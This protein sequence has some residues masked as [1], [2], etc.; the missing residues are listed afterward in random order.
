MDSLDR[1]LT[2]LH[3]SRLCLF[4]GSTGLA[5]PEN[6]TILVETSSLMLTSSH[7]LIFYVSLA[8]RE[9]IEKLNPK[10]RGLANEIRISVPASKLTIE[11]SSL[12]QLE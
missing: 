8:L 11:M 10:L 7:I 3:T 2:Y 4:P 1:S 5:K 6:G 12:D 9:K